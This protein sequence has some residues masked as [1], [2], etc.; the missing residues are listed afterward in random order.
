[1]INGV[2]VERTVK[3]VLPALETNSDGLKQVLDK[4][5]K[6]YKTKQDEM[7]KW[8]VCFI[9]ILVYRSLRACD[10]LRADVHGRFVEEEQRPGRAKPMRHSTLS[11]Y[12]KRV[13]P[14]AE[15]MRAMIVSSEQPEWARCHKQRCTPPRR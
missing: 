2:L 8:K 13:R 1:M 9:P 14:A 15:P 7:D 10:S 6:Q 12:Y 5:M 4:L 3:D 11:C